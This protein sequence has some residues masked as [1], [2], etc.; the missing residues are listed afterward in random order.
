MFEG[1]EREGWGTQPGRKGGLSFILFL[2]FPF[3]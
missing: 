2:D 1:E 3:W